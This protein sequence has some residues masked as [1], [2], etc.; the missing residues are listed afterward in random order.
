M[1]GVS[2]CDVYL[3]FIMKLVLVYTKFDDFFF[4]EGHPKD[5]HMD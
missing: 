1:C 4:Q 5:I 2:A 3:V